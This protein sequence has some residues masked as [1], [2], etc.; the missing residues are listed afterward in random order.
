MAG[1][2]A[3]RRIVVTGAARGLGW[4]FARDMAAQDARV[5]MLDILADELEQC[6]TQ[7]RETGAQVEHRVLDIAD[8]QAIERTFTC[9]LY[10]SPSP[11][12]CS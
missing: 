2:L 1:L 6:A 11:R 7:L 4:Q 10:T 5:V 9:L 8:P 12:D 3:G